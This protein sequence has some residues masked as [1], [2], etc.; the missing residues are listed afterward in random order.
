MI[1]ENLNESNLYTIEESNES[2]NILAWYTLYNDYTNIIDDNII[3]YISTGISPQ[4]IPYLVITHDCNKENDYKVN[5][6]Y[7]IDIYVSDGT[8]Y[9]NIFYYIQKKI[10]YL[11]ERPYTDYEKLVLNNGT[12]FTDLARKQPLMVP[13]TVYAIGTRDLWN[14]SPVATYEYIPTNTIYNIYGTYTSYI[15]NNSLSMG[16][17][18]KKSIDLSYTTVLFSTED[19]N[20]MVGHTVN[21]FIFTF[22]TTANQ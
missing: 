6:T 2:E 10:L 4:Y 3:A 7:R 9:V 18:S 20:K 8:P 13:A 15:D 12:L 16:W 17:D 1:T 22:D 21:T 11:L 14:N 5:R 19:N